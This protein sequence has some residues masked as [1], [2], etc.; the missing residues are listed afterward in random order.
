MSLVRLR[1]AA[2]DEVGVTAALPAA[3]V[4]SASVLSSGDGMLASCASMDFSKSMAVSFFSV[5]SR[6]T[7]AACAVALSSLEISARSS[8]IELAAPLSAI[9]TLDEAS[10]AAKA[11]SFFCSKNSA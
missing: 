11:V 8:K 1:V 3:T 7:S 9:D 5:S 4:I 10:K 2:S 6:E